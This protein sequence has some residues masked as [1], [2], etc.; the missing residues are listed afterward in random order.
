MLH[1]FREL[2]LFCVCSSFRKDLHSLGQRIVIS[3][4]LRNFSNRNGRKLLYQEDLGKPLQ[5]S[6][7]DTH[8]AENFKVELLPVFDP[9]GSTCIC[10]FFSTQNDNHAFCSIV[11]KQNKLE[12]NWT[13]TKLITRQPA[14]DLMK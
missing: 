8:S 9:Q 12:W 11:L 14:N 3:L 6:L 4:T 13:I 7:L 1:L 2:M 10:L 5:E